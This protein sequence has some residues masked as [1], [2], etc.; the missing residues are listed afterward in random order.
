MKD[1]NQKNLRDK[2]LKLGVKI[3]GPET[4]FFFK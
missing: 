4:V 3:I 1:F 2:F